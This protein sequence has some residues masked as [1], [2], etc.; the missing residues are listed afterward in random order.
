MAVDENSIVAFRSMSEEIR[1]RIRWEV[2]LAIKKFC[3]V[4]DIEIKEYLGWDINK[5]TGRRNE[6]AEQGKI[7]LVGKFKR[8]GKMRNV[9]AV[10][11]N[12]TQL[13]IKLPF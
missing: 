9:W 7:Y 4:F 6:L 11:K 3:E 2:Y 5:I 13:Q 12:E 1:L 8:R 10:T